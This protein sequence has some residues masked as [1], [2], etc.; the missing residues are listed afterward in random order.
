MFNNI[1]FSNHETEWNYQIEG[2]IRRVL[3]KT[4][5]GHLALKRAIDITR[6]KTILHFKN[7]LKWFLNLERK[8]G[9]L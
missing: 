6:L 3:Y 9:K 2:T 8:S 5:D 4:K 1:N 7:V